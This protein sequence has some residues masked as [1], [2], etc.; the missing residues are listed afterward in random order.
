MCRTRG[1]PADHDIVAPRQMPSPRKL[2]AYALGTALP[3]GRVDRGWD[4]RG[5]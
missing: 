3:E 4:P 2:L 5:S 1:Y